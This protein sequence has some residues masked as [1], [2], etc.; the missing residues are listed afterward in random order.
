[1]SSLYNIIVSRK[2]WDGQQLTQHLFAY[3][4]LLTIS[5]KLDMNQINEIMDV[6]SVHLKKESE[7]PLLEMLQVSA[8]I[9]CILEEKAGAALDGKKLMQ[10]NWPVNFRIV[11]RRLL[12]TPAI[13]FVSL[14]CE[15]NSS[16]KS[17]FGQYLPVLFELSDELISIIGSS[18][19]ESDPEFLLL[20][21][22]MSSIYL[23][24]VFQMKTSVG[25]SF[26]HG[27]LNCQFLRFGE[28]T[29]I[30]PDD[31]E[32]SISRAVLLSKILRQSAIYACEFCQSCDESSDVSK[33]III[34][35]FQFLCMYIDFGGLIV[36]PPESIKNLGKALL[37][38]SVDCSE[39]SL[40]PLE[41]FAKIICH[42]PNLPDITLDT[43][44]RTLNR[45]YT[46]RNKEDVVHVSNFTMLF[47]L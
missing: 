35:I 47:V 40:V 25:Q 5:S 13:V 43:I 36:L 23:Q 32:N 22:S 29:N 12:Q 30:L 37:Y 7:L 15:S 17:L 21:S 19:F 46:R 41:C 33:K 24:D 2:N 45:H 42:L 20:L 39:I 16:E 44:M 8:G 9:L 6:I 3:K 1:M 18:W 28:D 34:S 38:H 14:V 4:E 31:K 11:I 26:V 10:R 27:R